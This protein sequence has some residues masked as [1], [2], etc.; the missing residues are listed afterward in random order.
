MPAPEDAQ[1]RQALVYQLTPHTTKG[2][3]CVRVTAG[4][5][6]TCSVT[7]PSISPLPGLPR[8]QNWGSSLPGKRRPSWNPLPFPPGR[9]PGP[10]GLQAY[11]CPADGSLGPRASPR[12]RAACLGRSCA[13]GGAPVARG[14]PSS[15]SRQ[16]V[17]C[18]PTPHRVPGWASS[19][20]RHAQHQGG[21]SG[22]GSPPPTLS[23]SL[24]NC[25][26]APPPTPAGPRVLGRARAQA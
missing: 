14:P 10:A 20:P 26:W 22:C 8:Q 18:I 4:T 23:L 24:R 5:S 11:S 3:V 9:A 1:K 17:A 25:L 12:P 16:H 13:R 6:R 2:R 15:R 19:E 7:P 21:P